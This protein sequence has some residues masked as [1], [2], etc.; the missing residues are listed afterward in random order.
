LI[1]YGWPRL[2]EALPLGCVLY[3][4]TGIRCPFC[5]MTRDFLTILHGSWPHQNVFSVPAAFVIWFV[6][7]AW[8][9]SNWSRL[10]DDRPIMDARFVWAVL[11][12][13]AFVAKARPVE[14]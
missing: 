3:A 4:S 13:M 9:W 6:Y 14:P 2:I 12:F 10:G 7:P 8:A 1:A 11:I 5:G